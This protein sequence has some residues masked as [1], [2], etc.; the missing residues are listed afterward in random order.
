MG[1]GAGL[2]ALEEAIELEQMRLAGT[3]NAHLAASYK[4]DARYNKNHNLKAWNDIY[5][6]WLPHYRTYTPSDKA[7]KELEFDAHRVR[8]SRATGG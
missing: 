4:A 2:V 7:L 5:E 8:N 3:L 6:I 1:K